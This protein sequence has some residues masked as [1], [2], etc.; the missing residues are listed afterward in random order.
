MAFAFVMNF[1]S[2]G[3]VFTGCYIELLACKVLTMPLRYYCF[4]KKH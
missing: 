4:Y 1:G 2:R 3:M